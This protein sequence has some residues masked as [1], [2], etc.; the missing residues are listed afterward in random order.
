MI[1]VS[2]SS[3]GFIKAAG[4]YS[5]V[6]LNNRTIT[7]RGNI[8]SVGNR[9]VKAKH[10]SM[11]R[12]HRSYLINSEKIEKIS[13]TDVQIFSIKIPSGKNGLYKQNFVELYKKHEY[14]QV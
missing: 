5:E 14:L 7:I 11:I 1:S 6:Y 9:L 3:I 8:K 13:S 2:I 12:I 10:L 4:N